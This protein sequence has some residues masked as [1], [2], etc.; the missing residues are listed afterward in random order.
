MPDHQV[1][2]PLSSARRGKPL[3]RQHALAVAADVSQ[4]AAVAAMVERVVATW[5]AINLLHNHAGLLHPDDGSVLDI[6][7]AAIDRTLA[8][9][10]KG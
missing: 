4:A 6:T 8:V 2:L 3:G 7:E 1:R 9:N 5:G 10:V